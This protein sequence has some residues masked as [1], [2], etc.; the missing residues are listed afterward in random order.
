MLVCGCLQAPPPLT[1]LYICIVVTASLVAHAGAA[2]AAAVL[3]C[4]GITN[5]PE[6]LSTCGTSA[7]TA[8]HYYRSIFFSTGKP[9]EAS[10]CLFMAAFPH[11]CP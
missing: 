5:T 10:R 9:V 3:M 8:C 11:P 6:H 7:G 2:A 1:T 4:A